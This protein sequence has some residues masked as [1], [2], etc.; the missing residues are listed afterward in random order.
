MCS[1]DLPCTIAI[2]GGVV[3]V[4][5][6]GVGTCT[7]TAT[8]PT[9]GNFLAATSNTVVITIAPAVGV[10]TMNTATQTV[11]WGTAFTA[12]TATTNS[13]A[14]VAYT[15]SNTAVAT[16]NATTG[17]VTIVG[18]GTTTITAS[19]PAAANYT[20]ATP[21][22]YQLVVIAGSQVL[23]WDAATNGISSQA[24][25]NSFSIGA[26]SSA[27]LT[28]T[29]AVSGG[30]TLAGTTVTMTSGTTSCV[31]T[32]DQ[33]GSATTTA[34]PQISKTVAAALAVQNPLLL[35]ATTTSLT[36]N[37]STP[38]STALQ[39][40]GGSGTGAVTVGVGAGEPCSV[41]LSGGIWTL[42]SSGAG[43]CHV[44][45]T[46]AADANYQSMAASAL[47]VTVEIGRAHV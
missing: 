19:V 36:Y 10:I 15:S 23:S 39:I 21:V 22:S 14:A 6:N 29:Y 3:T 40:S 42:T 26:T 12:P 35:S 1:S 18:V 38:A 37:P 4:S 28:P 24:F 41:A 5:A 17:A 9:D 32:A 8:K 11:T 30:C 13:T 46:R 45:A 16:V 44:S 34:A 47:V 2:A 27:A 33:A 31:I 7:I 25:G 43:T 20:A